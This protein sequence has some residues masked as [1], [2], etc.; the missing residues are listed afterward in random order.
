VTRKSVRTGKGKHKKTV[1]KCTTKLTSSPVKFHHL[2]RHDCSRVLTRR[3]HLRH[4]TSEPRGRPEHAAADTAT[5]D[6]QGQ[7]HPD[8]HT[9]RQPPTRDD[10]DLISAA[11]PAQTQ[12]SPRRCDRRYRRP[13]AA[14]LGRAS[15]PAQT[16]VRIRARISS[17]TSRVLLCAASGSVQIPQPRSWRI[18][19][20]PGYRSTDPLSRQRA[21]LSSHHASFESVVTV[22]DDAAEPFSGA[23]GY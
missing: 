14:T 12:R 22:R 8:A 16:R 6:P 1:Q 18:T 11:A 10:H 15:R 3:R 23:P 4:R 17:L 7:L 21:N 13:E 19:R 20:L 5:R 9:P 2:A